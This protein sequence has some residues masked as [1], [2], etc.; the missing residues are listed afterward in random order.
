MKPLSQQTER[1][2]VPVAH[3]SK[4]PPGTAQ[5]LQ[6]QNKNS[7]T[8]YGSEPVSRTLQRKRKHSLSESDDVIDLTQD[9]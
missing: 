2:D 7:N 8:S 4:Q 3:N 5:N 1:R 9:S 6:T